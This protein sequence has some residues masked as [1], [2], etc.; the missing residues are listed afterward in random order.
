MAKSKTFPKNQISSVV[1]Y[2]F[3]SLFQSIKNGRVAAA[4]L[5]DKYLQSQLRKILQSSEDSD[6]FHD[7]RVCSPTKDII[8]SANMKHIYSPTKDIIQSANMKHINSSVYITVFHHEG[9]FQFS[10]CGSRNCNI[11]YT[12]I[13]SPQYPFIDLNPCQ[14]L[15]IDEETRT[16]ISCANLVQVRGVFEVMMQ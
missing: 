11:V 15:S 8:Q 14:L 2:S 3:Y 4:K 16:G 12:W 10:N 6:I 13:S 7:F 9:V 1:D 5:F